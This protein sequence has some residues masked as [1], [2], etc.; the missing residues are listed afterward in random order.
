MALDIEFRKL[1]EVEL[2]KT[3][4]NIPNEKIPN[5]TS[6]WNCES[7][8]DFLY[9]WHMAKVDDFC[10]NQFFAKFHKNPTVEDKREIQGILFLHGKDY[11]D[12]L[13]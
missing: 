6:I 3:L 4:N 10:T 2:E 12:K 11:L 13:Q 8:N 9:G 5:I 7:E 1:L